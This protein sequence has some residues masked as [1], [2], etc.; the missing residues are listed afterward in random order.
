M[1]KDGI[2]RASEKTDYQEIEKGLQKSEGRQVSA[3]QP[4]SQR[5]C[6]TVF[7]KISNV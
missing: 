2:L 7:P 5:L 4:P 1:R 3:R 6:R